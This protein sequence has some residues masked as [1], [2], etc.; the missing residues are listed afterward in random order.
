MQPE[1]ASVT[2]QLPNHANS[3]YF[4]I[5]TT[6]MRIRT[7]RT[8]ISPYW[9]AKYASIRF[10]TTKQEWQLRMGTSSVICAH[11]DLKWMMAWGQEFARA[12]NI[13]VR[14]ISP[15]D[16]K[17]DFIEDIRAEAMSD[18]AQERAS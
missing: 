13:E 9:R 6:T 12:E 18:L 10:S 16:S 3:P 4:Q 2:F 14:V 17:I 8:Q 5:E 7:R 1:S 11:T 15:H